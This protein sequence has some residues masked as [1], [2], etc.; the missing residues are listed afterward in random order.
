MAR[1]AYKYFRVEAR[2]LLEQ[3]GQGILDLEKQGGAA[4]DTWLMRWV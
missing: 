3:L 1:D 4:L 2:E